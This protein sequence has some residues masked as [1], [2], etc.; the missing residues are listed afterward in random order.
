MME[1]PNR[2]ILH[3]FFSFCVVQTNRIHMDMGTRMQ[4][5]GIGSK[6]IGSSMGDPERL[7]VHIFAPE[8][9]TDRIHNSDVASGPGRW[10]E[11]DL[12]HTI[13]LGLGLCI[14]PPNH[15]FTSASKCVVVFL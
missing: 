6:N 14:L 7:S 8:S 10:G 2:F 5:I 9:Q 12:N 3:S 1:S 4:Y 15:I 11:G 13:L